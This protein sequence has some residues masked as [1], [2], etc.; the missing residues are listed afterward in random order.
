MVWFF[1]DLWLSI[2]VLLSYSGW[3]LCRFVG[4]VMLLRLFVL[5]LWR[6]LRCG[7][8]F[9]LM[10]L[11][12]WD[13]LRFC[14]MFRCLLR[15]GVILWLLW[16]GLLL[17]VVFI[18][19]NLWLILWLRCWWMCSCVMKCWCFWLCWCCSNF[20]RLRCIMIF[21]VSILWLRV[22]RWLRFVLLCCMVLSVCV[23]RLWWGLWVKCYVG[24]CGG[25]VW[26]YLFLWMV[27]DGFWVCFWEVFW[28]D[29]CDN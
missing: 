16:L 9:M 28:N 1:R 23:V 24:V 18:V 22:L 2:C 27:R 6:R 13:C 7:I 10:C 15:C 19:M 17:M 20:M 26:I 29:D 3:F 21:F 14:C 5:F 25:W 11:R 4:I 12:C 8:L